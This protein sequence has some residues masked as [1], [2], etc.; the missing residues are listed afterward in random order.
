[1]GLV[2]LVLL[3]PQDLQELPVRDG[4]VCEVADATLNGLQKK[5]FQCSNYNCIRPD[6]RFI[7]PYDRCGVASYMK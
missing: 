6:A 1:M 2:V 5:P 3:V 4:G 7:Q